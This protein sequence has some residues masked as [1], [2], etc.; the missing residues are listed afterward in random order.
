MEMTQ[1][2]RHRSSI[3]LAVVV[4]TLVPGA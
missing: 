1:S 4:C 3:A 2:N